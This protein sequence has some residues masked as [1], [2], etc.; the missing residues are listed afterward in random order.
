MR[1]EIESH[2]NPP[3]RRTKHIKNVREGDVIEMHGQAHL[4]RS[5]QIFV[6]EIMQWNCEHLADG[7]VSSTYL[8]AN[9]PA[10]VPLYWDCQE[11]LAPG[12][13]PTLPSF[14]TERSTLRYMSMYLIDIQSD[15][16]MHLM[17]RPG[18]PQGY[19]LTVEIPRGSL[20]DI[21]CETEAGSRE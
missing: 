18:D 6:Y 19:Q 21:I 17:A 7:T 4:V 13:P 10:Q 12:G 11:T 14:N 16:H 3:A 1:A 15:T 20:G 2:R 8:Q 9:H 5:S